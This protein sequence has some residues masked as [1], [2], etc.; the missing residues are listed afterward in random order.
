MISAHID[1]K[2]G[3]PGAIDNATGVITLLLL[4]ERLKGY[5]GQSTIEFVAFN[6]EDYYAIPGQN[7]YFR[8][9]ED[10]MHTIALNINIDGAGYCH[11]STAISFY[12]CPPS[13]EEPLKAMLEDSAGIMEGAQWIQSDHGIFVMSGIPAIA[14]TSDKF[15]DTLSVEITH[16]SNDKPEIVD[17]SKLVAISEFLERGIRQIT[18]S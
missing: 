12:S 6:G 17:C 13:V 2:K 10:R 18:S 3:T 5:K 1:S 16:T 8:H 11:N 9:N 15:M 14:I 4:A 7:L